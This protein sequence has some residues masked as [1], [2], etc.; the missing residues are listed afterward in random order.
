MIGKE[1]QK[2]TK[3]LA[4]L[5]Y[6]LAE[7]TYDEA[8]GDESVAVAKVGEFCDQ[9]CS[10]ATA[11]KAAAGQKFASIT[12]LAKAAAIA[13]VCAG[14]RK[15][16]FNHKILGSQ[17]GLPHEELGTYKLE[18][19]PSSASSTIESNLRLAKIEFFTSGFL[20]ENL[21]LTMT[22][23]ATSSL[24]GNKQFKPDT[25]FVI[26]QDIKITKLRTSFYKLADFFPDLFFLTQIELTDSDGVLIW[27]FGSEGKNNKDFKYFETTVPEDETVVGFQV[28]SFTENS[29]IYGLGLVTARNS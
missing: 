19:F 7:Y 12:S 22:D 29:G 14:E 8:K 25:T 18:S 6:N 28:A 16:N 20:L 11:I 15:L 4:E 24:L 13:K 9:I 1:L 21:K 5:A 10:M 23:G 27:K 2:T 26:P 3:K 17:T